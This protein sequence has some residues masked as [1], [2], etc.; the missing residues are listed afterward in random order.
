MRTTID[1]AGRLVLPKSM[2]DALGL[3][4][5]GEVD[6]ELADGY[7]TISPPTVAKRLDVRGGRAV[8]VSDEPLPPLTDD[9]VADTLDAIRP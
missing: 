7:V 6:L 4:E 3:G 2:R 1:R 8:I 9:V 5:G